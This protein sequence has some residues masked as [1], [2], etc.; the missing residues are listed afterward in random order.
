[1]WFDFITCNEVEIC[2]VLFYNVLQMQGW[3]SLFGWPDLLVYAK[4]GSK[5]NSPSIVLLFSSRLLEKIK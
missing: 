4:S 1:M 3:V 5:W 2:R